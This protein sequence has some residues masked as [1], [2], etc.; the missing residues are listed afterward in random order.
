MSR[1]VARIGPTIISVVALTE[2]EIGGAAAWTV[3]AGVTCIEGVRV[4]TACGTVHDAVLTSVP[5]LRIYSTDAK[6]EPCEILC[7][8]VGSSPVTHGNGNPKEQCD[9]Y[10]LNVKVKGGDTIHFY[11]TQYVTTTTAPWMGIDVYFNTTGPAGPQYHYK[12]CAAVFATTVTAAAAHRDPTTYRISGKRI[13]AAMG[14]VWQTT[15]TA[16]VGCV[17]FFSLNSTDFNT[18]YGIEWNQ[19]GGGG[20]LSVGDLQVYLT[21]A[22]F[23]NPLTGPQLDISIKDPCNITQ[24]WTNG[25]TNI[26]GA[27]VTGVQYI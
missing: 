3:P 5:R 15:S 18:P 22:G 26:V 21:Q 24:T 14:A 27:F 12:A 25:P 16:A 1:S 6:I 2:T 23:F 13:T 4:S 8:V 11:G 19:Q 20:I 17:G 10:P 7:P 9:F